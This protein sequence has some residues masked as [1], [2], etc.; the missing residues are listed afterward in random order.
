MEPRYRA[1]RRISIEV[2]GVTGGMRTSTSSPPGY[3]VYDNL[4]ALDLPEF[5]KEQTEAEEAAKK[6]N[7][8]E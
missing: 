3:S 5:Y 1:R 4:K 7:S 8:A 2:G 6:L